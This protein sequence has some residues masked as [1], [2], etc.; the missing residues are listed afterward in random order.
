MP[1]RVRDTWPT[2]LLDPARAAPGLDVAAALLAFQ[3]AFFRSER[4]LGRAAR[5]RPY[6]GLPQ[7][8]DQPADGVGAIALLGAEALGMDHDHA[9]LGHALAGEPAQSRCG[10]RGKRYAPRIE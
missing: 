1:H 3:A 7:K 2:L 8:L 6:R 5:R 9:V 10:V 4:R